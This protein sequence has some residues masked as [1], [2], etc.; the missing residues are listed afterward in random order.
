MKN[1]PE[2]INRAIQKG[3]DLDGTQISSSKLDL[4]NKI[5]ELESKRERYRATDCMRT[6]IVR[7]AHNYFSLNEINVELENAGWHL[8]TEKERKFF[9]EK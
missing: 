4:Y 6:R 9:F 7:S 3:V 2:D 5:K 8:V 1:G